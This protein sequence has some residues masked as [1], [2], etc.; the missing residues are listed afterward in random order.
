[1][2]LWGGLLAAIADP[3]SA[4]ESGFLDWMGHGFVFDPEA[5]D[6]AAVNALFEPR[7]RRRR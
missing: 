5:F 1:V 6:T 2:G 3:E 7:S 4:E